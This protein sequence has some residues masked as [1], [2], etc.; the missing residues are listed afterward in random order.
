MTEAS[1][2]EVSIID[3]LKERPASSETISNITGL[4][5]NAIL[6]KLRRMENWGILKPVTRRKMIIWGLVKD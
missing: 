4:P 2:L 3:I 6:M 1:D 5:T